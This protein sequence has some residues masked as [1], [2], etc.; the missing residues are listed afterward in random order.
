MTASPQVRDTSLN[1][2]Q[3]TYNAAA[4]VFEGCTM[5]SRVELFGNCRWPSETAHKRLMGDRN[6]RRYRWASGDP[7]N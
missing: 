5:T 2:G 3:S 7:E 1:G 4:S 6:G